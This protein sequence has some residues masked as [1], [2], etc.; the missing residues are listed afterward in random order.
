MLALVVALVAS[1]H[2]SWPMPSEETLWEMFDRFQHHYTKQY[3]AEDV[4]DRFAAF[5]GNVAK[6]IALNEKRGSNC[7][8]LFDDCPYGVTPFSDKTVEQ[9]KRSMTG[10]KSGSVSQDAK[11]MSPS[12]YAHG[13][14][15]QSK[16]WRTEGKVSAIKDQNPCGVCWAFSATSTIES[17]YAIKYAT[18]PPVLSPEMIVDCDGTHACHGDT[19]GGLYW[20]AWEWLQEEGGISSLSSYPITCCDETEDPVIGQCPA[21]REHEVK[22]TSYSFG[23]SD[24]DELAAAVATQGPFSIA[25][26][27]DAWQHWK[28]GKK[29]MLA[30]ECTGDI[31]HA[32]SIVGFD[33]SADVPYW[34]VRNQ[35][36]TSWGDEGYIYLAFGSNTCQL[37]ATSGFP[38]VSEST[39]F[40]E[41]IV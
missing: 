41:V 31:D 34:I 32:V 25:V 38:E 17:A 4:R 40:P 12:R 23:P 2:A 35:W 26:A 20:Q 13:L 3:E 30:S 5:K 16:D 8:D 11:V 19:S 18:S 24:E 7:T 9:F 39:L 14:S 28:G 22:V 6:A 15:V 27:S 10:S 1:C 33:K 37:T 36:G 29:V 21:G